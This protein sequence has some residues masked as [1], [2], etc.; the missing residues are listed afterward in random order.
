MGYMQVAI[1]VLGRFHAFDLA[2]EL[3]RR[4]ALGQLI[5]SYPAYFPREKFSIRAESL[6]T[7][8][9]IEL[10]RRGFAKI[11]SSMKHVWDGEVEMALLFDRWAALSLRPEQ[12]VF[13]G[14]SGG[15]LHSIERAKSLGMTTVLERGSAHILQQVEGLQEEYAKR[16]LRYDETPREVIEKELLEY[17]A[18]DFVCVPSQFAYR[19]FLEKGFPKEKL[20]VNPCGVNLQLFQ[21]HPRR[22]DR[23]RVVFCGGVTILKG[24]PYLVEAFSKLKLP[25]SELVLIGN[26][27][28]KIAKWLQVKINENPNIKWIGVCPQDKLSEK[29]SQADLFCLPSIGDGFGMVVPQALASGVPVLTTH[30]V[31]AADVIHEGVNGFVV[32][33]MSEIDLM[34]KIQWC[35]EH[36]SECRQMG[37]TAAQIAKSDLSWSAYGDRAF[38]L[39]QKIREGTAL[40]TGVARIAS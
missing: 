7:A 31:G 8:P 40:E 32:R 24:V 36:R 30:H 2:R 4:D 35:Y 17:E 26:L 25:D 27:S 6:T 37:I 9:W 28:P 39:Y 5:T 33:P 18:S 14:W 29:L 3:A 15:A 34:E 21:P 16:G 22:D 38:H 19:T 10:L 12:E 1:S 11:P 23:F 13:V 20:L